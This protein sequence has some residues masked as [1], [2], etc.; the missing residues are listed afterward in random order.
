MDDGAR[1]RLLS[2]AQPR[3]TQVWKK[4]KAEV[5]KRIRAKLKRAWKRAHGLTRRD[6]GAIGAG[7]L[8]VEEAVARRQ[9]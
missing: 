5:P 9:S 7:H 3:K 6:M 2:A 1:A 4:Q 8:T